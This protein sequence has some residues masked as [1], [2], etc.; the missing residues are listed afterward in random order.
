MLS[1]D[2]GQVLEDQL[3]ALRLP[4]PGLSGDDDALV[5][6]RPPHERVAVV[7]DGEDVRRQLPDLLLLVHLDL[8]GRVD[9]QDLVGVD[10]HQDGTRVRLFEERETNTK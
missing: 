3:G 9:R 1:R 5:L 7:A 8:V 10:R 6:E 2:G 4:G